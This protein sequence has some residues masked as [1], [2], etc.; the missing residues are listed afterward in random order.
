LK[1]LANLRLN[2]N[3]IT[4]LPVRVFEL[5]PQLIEA[6]LMGN[7]IRSINDQNFHPTSAQ[8][9]EY[10]NLASNKLDAIGSGAFESLPR[11][12]ILELH[13]NNLAH[14][15]P[16]TFNSLPNL[17][18]LDLSKNN[19]GTLHD[20]AFNQL[21]ALKHLNLGHNQLA[22]IGESV[23]QNVAALEHLILSHNLL[24]SFNFLFLN[25]QVESLMALDLSYNKLLRFET[26]IN[27]LNKHSVLGLIWTMRNTS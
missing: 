4:G 27:V 23:F 16:Q 1:K 24:T 21:P 11:L 19:I 8:K 15:N 9:L 7:Q 14:I 12:S 25:N 22:K 13:S 20:F 5:T 6:H 10:L 26:F 2:N 17:N 18:H 3:K